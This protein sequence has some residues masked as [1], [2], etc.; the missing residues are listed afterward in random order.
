MGIH[1]QLNRRFE[2]PLKNDVEI[3]SEEDYLKGELEA[4]VKH[5]YIDGQI[6]AM[7]GASA[8][9]N[10]LSSTISR[11]FGNHLKGKPCDAFQSDFKVKVGTKYFY[12]DVVVRC[13]KDDDYY[14][15]K[16]V[17]IVEVLSD[18]TR[19]RDEITKLRAY[20]T[21]P[22]L[23]EYVLV[24]QDVVRVEVFSRIGEFWGSKIYALGDSIHFESIGLTLSVEE[25]YE[26]VDNEDMKK[27]L[28]EKEG[29]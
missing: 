27:Y 20:Q 24:S 4:E 11:E 26:S 29:E 28:K 17:I 22:S 12:P 3:V 21:I 15:Q 7:V 6:Y 16:P 9:H 10:S 13:D 1:C 23:M 25:I 8:N 19:R 18:S 5:E 2:M 14:T